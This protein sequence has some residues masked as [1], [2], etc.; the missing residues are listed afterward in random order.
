MFASVKTLLHFKWAYTNSFVSK[1]KIGF[2]PP[3]YDKFVLTK[4]YQ[5][6][7]DVYDHLNFGE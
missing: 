7:L 3:K 4:A 5:S 2:L 6:I 1:S